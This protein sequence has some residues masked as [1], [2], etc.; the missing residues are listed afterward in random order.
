MVENNEEMGATIIYFPGPRGNIARRLDS[1]I[2]ALKQSNPALFLLFRHIANNKIYEKYEV[3][4][5]V[6]DWLALLKQH[7]EIPIIRRDAL[8]EEIKNYTDEKLSNLGEL[9]LQKKPDVKPF[10]QC[11]S[12]F[13]GDR[14]H[15]EENIK[16]TR[17]YCGLIIKLIIICS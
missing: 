11:L 7:L 13:I 12:S 6:Y 9:A 3:I 15:L 17:L 14:V 5:C 4:S 16:I 10:I 2:D 8:E 1:K